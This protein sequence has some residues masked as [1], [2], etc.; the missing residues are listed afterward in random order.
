LPNRCHRPLRIHLAILSSL[1]SEIVQES[2]ANVCRSL[3]LMHFQ[4]C[5]YN[6]SVRSVFL[7]TSGQDRRCS[8]SLASP[9]VRRCNPLTWGQLS[10][11]FLYT[12]V[13]PPSES[14]EKKKEKERQKIKLIPYENNKPFDMIMIVDT[15][16]GPVMTGKLV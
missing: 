1:E 15:L 16:S 6:L 10:G 11:L 8:S 14:T 12:E 2:C 9:A 3:N 7:I 4:L 13:G 5:M